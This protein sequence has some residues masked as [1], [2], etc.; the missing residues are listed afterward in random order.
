MCV[1]GVMRDVDLHVS[2]VLRLHRRGHV[3]SQSLWRSP[4]LLGR[5]LVLH[6]AVS[7]DVDAKDDPIVEFEAVGLVEQVGF[8]DNL[9]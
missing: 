8:L 2:A 4:G 3:L 1:E 7:G 6:V 5:H 9:A